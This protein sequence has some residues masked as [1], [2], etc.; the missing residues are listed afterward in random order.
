[1]DD[2]SLITSFIVVWWWISNPIAWYKLIRLKFEIEL[3]I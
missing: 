1:V 2:F 3:R